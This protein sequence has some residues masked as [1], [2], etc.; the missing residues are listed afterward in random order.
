METVLNYCL[1]KIVYS[2]LQTLMLL[3]E[4]TCFQA[5]PHAL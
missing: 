4:D 5:L 2:G 1:Y 3:A